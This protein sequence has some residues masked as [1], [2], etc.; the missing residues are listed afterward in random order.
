MFN[1]LKI[2]FFIITTILVGNALMGQKLNWMFSYG[3]GVNQF[4]LNTTSELIQENVS[5]TQRIG[6]GAYQFIDKEKKWNY[7]IGLYHATASSSIGM[8][9]S[10]GDYSNRPNF[11][12][13]RSKVGFVSIPVTLQRNLTINNQIGFFVNLGASLGLNPVL[14]NDMLITSNHSFANNTWESNV[15]T[16][17]EPFALAFG[18]GAVGFR[19]LQ[20]ENWIVEIGVNGR[21]PVQ[22]KGVQHG[23][24]TIDEMYVNGPMRRDIASFTTTGGWFGI[25]ISLKYFEEF[26]PIDLPR[27]NR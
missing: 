25:T 21:L 22:N 15:T 10:F 4:G 18:E 19:F 1:H 20:V 24:I 7:N 14:G 27:F 5:I 16:S 23:D 6:F 13:Y 11:S 9:V 17:L 26:K 8:A 12:Q 3:Q 2:A